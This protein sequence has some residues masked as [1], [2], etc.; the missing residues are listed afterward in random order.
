MN[1]SE[2]TPF[3]IM[4]L[5]RKEE[6]LELSKVARGTSTTIE[7]DKARQL[8]PADLTQTP[9]LMDDT[10]DRLRTEMDQIDGALRRI[11]SGDYGYCFKCDEELDPRRLHAN[12]T[13]TRCIACAA[14]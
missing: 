6:L 7:P 1:V 4:L 9:P 12:P 2:L 10:Q 11:T 14:K 5:A 3:K 13:L 8:S